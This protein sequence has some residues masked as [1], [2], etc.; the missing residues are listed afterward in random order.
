MSGGTLEHR[1]HV[2]ALDGLRGAAILLVLLHA[3]NVIHVDS[4]ATRLADLAL[5]IGWIGVQLFFV[6]SGF[7]ITGIL[8]D[9][10]GAPGYWRNFFMR[11]V[12]RIFPLYYVALL[13]AFVIL[14]AFL[15]MPAG[16]GEHQSW[17]WLYIENIGAPFGHVEAGFTHFWSLCVEEQFYL[18]WPLLVWLGGQRGVFVIGAA[19]VVLAVFT[20]VLARMYFPGD[21]GAEI[22]YVFTLCRMDALAIG[23]MAACAVRNPRLHAGLERVGAARLLVAGLALTLVAIQIG[24]WQRVGAA[25]QGFGYTGIAAGFA[26]VLLAVLFPA[27]LAA[28]SMAMAPLRSVGKVSYAMYVVHAPLHV[29]VGLPLLERWVPQPD[30]LQVIVYAL[31]MGVV[32]WLLGLLSWQVFERHFIALK[33]H[34]PEPRRAGAA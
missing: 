3:F 14:S 28:R 12:L 10:R 23:A 4:L 30:M 18:L 26:L 31:L 8:L 20:R 19:L 6:L 1:G 27:G 15:P 32:T 5:N 34:F 13:L 22:G 7:L 24:G 21:L 17:L 25:M 9:T 11:R 33:R 2:P 29:H 16:H